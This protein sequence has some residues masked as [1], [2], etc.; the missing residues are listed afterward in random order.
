MHDPRTSLDTSRRFSGN[1]KP[2]KVRRNAK[3]KSTINLLSSFKRF[4]SNG[5]GS[6]RSRLSRTPSEIRAARSFSVPTS[7]P[8][9]VPSNQAQLLKLRTLNRQEIGLGPPEP[10]ASGLRSVSEPARPSQ[11]ILDNKPEIQITLTPFEA[12]IGTGHEVTVVAELA[13]PDQK[14]S[15]CNTTSEKSNVEIVVLIDSESYETPRSQNLV[16]SV[17]ECLVKSLRTCGTTTRVILICT[18]ELYW[19][20]ELSTIKDVAMAMSEHA[21]MSHELLFH[22][23]DVG[24]VNAQRLRSVPSG[25][26]AHHTARRVIVLSH[27]QPDLSRVANMSSDIPVRLV[28]TQ[29]GDQA[30]IC[31]ELESLLLLTCK[32]QKV[33]FAIVPSA[34]CHQSVD[35]RNPLPHHIF[36]LSPGE[37][38]SVAFKL[39]QGNLVELYDP[40]GED[41]ASPRTASPSAAGTAMHDPQLPEDLHCFTPEPFLAE[42]SPK[43]ISERS[44][45]QPLKQK[46]NVMKVQ[47]ITSLLKLK[48]SKDQKPAPLRL[49]RIRSLRHRRL[50]SNGDLF[51]ESPK[52]VAT[53]VQ[54]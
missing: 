33:G 35:G 5:Q 30:R 3:S 47:S 21:S 40:E 38:R 43:P 24:L 48:G 7:I 17:L 6:K 2:P 23:L 15:R 50:S 29:N 25:H 18:A 36:T 10:R 49:E 42:S 31:A 1:L 8:T 51:S 28:S 32:W 9:R 27:Q 13:Y 46:E 20:R 44:V 52:S 53:R 14:H 22:S 41:Q 11:T 16:Q 39:R 54:W 4:L 26:S 34:I 37:R 19:K 45:L 12:T